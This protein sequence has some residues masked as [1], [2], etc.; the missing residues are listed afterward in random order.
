MPSFEKVFNRRMG[1]GRPGAG[2][3]VKS[4]LIPPISMSSA[5]ALPCAVGVSQVD[6]FVV[7]GGLPNMLLALLL[8]FQS[9]D[10]FEFPLNGSFE[11]VKTL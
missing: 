3:F 8:K 10:G 1:G 9:L 7:L 6:A 4:L 11:G 5:L 2:D